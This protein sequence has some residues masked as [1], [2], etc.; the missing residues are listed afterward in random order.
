MEIQAN[1]YNNIDNLHDA[2]IDWDYPFD[3]P[4]HLKLVVDNDNKNKVVY[5]NGKSF[6]TDESGLL[7]PL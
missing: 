6:W 4:N 7:W 5:L 1:I 2:V 3:V